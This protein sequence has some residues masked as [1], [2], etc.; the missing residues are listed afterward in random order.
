MKQ[1]ILPAI[2]IFL[3]IL[4]ISVFIIRYS[5]ATYPIVGND[6]KLFI[7]RLIDSHLF[8]KVNGFG[9]EW[10]T[11]SFGGGLPAY[12]NPLQMQFSLPQLITWFANPLVAVLATTAIYLAIGFVV[13]F[14]FMRDMLDFNYLS[15]ILGA[16]FFVASG[17][18]IERVVVG[19]V[20]KI[21]F[22]LIVIPIFALFN[23][24]LPAWLAGALISITGAILINSGGVYIGV[25]CLFT[26]LVTL[27]IIYFLKPSL[28]SW[29]KI[30]LVLI[31]GTILTL[32]LCGSKLYAITTLMQTFPR[33]E[34]SLFCF[35]VFKFGGAYFP[36]G[37]RNDY[38]S[39]TAANR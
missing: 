7:P 30:L 16:N 18:F 25:M 2:F 14:L 34:R 5:T 22:P 6:Y 4:V 33:C 13:T 38:T 36:A 29:K 20:D 21:T 9:I 8:Y 26:T 24:K 19:H 15:A 17:F 1:R 32:L 35:L 28:F 10:Y 37:G 31:W 39:L 12:P 11:P 23:P 27:P 3:N